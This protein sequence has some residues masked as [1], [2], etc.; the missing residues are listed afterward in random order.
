MESETKIKVECV[1]LGEERAEDAVL[2]RKLGVGLGL[3]VVL[4][5]LEPNSRR[6][7]WV[8]ESIYTVEMEWD[9]SSSSV[10]K[11]FEERKRRPKDEVLSSG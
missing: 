8:H 4:V 7:S 10:A 11:T 6:T 2:G 9:W 1:G 5:L 3:T